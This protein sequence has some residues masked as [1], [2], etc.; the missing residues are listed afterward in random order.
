M[1]LPPLAASILKARA[2]ALRLP[3]GRGQ[4]HT[5]MPQD[6]LLDVA[7]QTLGLGLLAPADDEL[8]LL[9]VLHAGLGPALAALDALD[10]AVLPAEPDLDPGR[11]PARPV[12]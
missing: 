12:T 5:V 1:C 9:P 8:A 4:T 2:G 3:G 6:A 11:A 10:L 7:R